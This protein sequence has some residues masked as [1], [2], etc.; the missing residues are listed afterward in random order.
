MKR[1]TEFEK[2][3]LSKKDN[4]KMAL[5]YLLCTS[6]AGIIQYSS[7][8]LLHYVVHFDSLP[9][10]TSLFHLDPNVPLEYGPSYF[11]ALVLSV[12]FNFTVNRKFTFKSANNVPKA[13]LKVF[14]YYCVFTP[15]SLWWGEAMAQHGINYNFVLIFTMFINLVTEFTFNRFVVFGKSIN[16]AEGTE[17]KEEK[18]P[19]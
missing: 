2:P 10:F 14:G 4:V 19:E 13:M 3:Q 12:I 11:V 8:S 7:A 9:L 18:K 17:N 6:G 1:E 5:K 15:A 16:S